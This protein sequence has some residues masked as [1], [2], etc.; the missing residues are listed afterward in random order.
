MVILMSRKGRTPKIK[1]N[2]VVVDHILCPYTP[3]TKEIFFREIQSDIY[4]IAKDGKNVA[5]QQLSKELREKLISMGFVLERSTKTDL[6]ARK[7][8]FGITISIQKNLQGKE[9]KELVIAVPSAS[10]AELIKKR[11]I[12]INGIKAVIPNLE[13]KIATADKYVRC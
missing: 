12:M 2:R 9:I 1:D 4:N 10:Q 7:K 8:V 3:I 6:E 5:A 13:L 11:E